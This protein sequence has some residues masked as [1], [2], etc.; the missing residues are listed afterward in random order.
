MAHV[1]SH[2]SNVCVYVGVYVGVLT[3]SYI[4]AQKKK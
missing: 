1:Y 4:P 2:A 3:R